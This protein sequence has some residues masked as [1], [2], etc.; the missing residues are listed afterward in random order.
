[1]RKAN[2]TVPVEVE[3]LFT[4]VSSGDSVNLQKL[5][6]KIL[7]QAT[8]VDPKDRLKQ[9]V[10]IY[11]KGN[12]K[13]F[14]NKSAL[15][16]ALQSNHRNAEKIVEIILAAGADA[17]QSVVPIEN[18]NQI[19]V[20]PLAIL[21][22]K[23]KQNLVRLLLGAQA[24]S[25][26]EFD[27][28]SSMDLL[29]V[30]TTG[31]ASTIKSISPLALCSIT[32]NVAM[33]QILLAHG[34]KH[35]H[36]LQR[37]RD[38][39]IRALTPFANS[40]STKSFP[41]LGLLYRHYAINLGAQAEIIPENQK[42]IPEF[43]TKGMII[44]YTTITE[45]YSIIEIKQLE[46]EL[47]ISI[48]HHPS[49]IT[50]AAYKGRLDIIQH[51]A[52]EQF[53]FKKCYCDCGYLKG[54]TPLIAAVLG[55]H[56]GLVAKL[57]SLKELI[58]MNEEAADGQYHHYTALCC[59]CDLGDVNMVRMLKSQGADIYTISSD[60]SSPL[61]LAVSA[62]EN[63]QKIVALLLEKDV[64]DWQNP[65]HLLIRML[66]YLS[67]HQ[68]GDAQLI[69]MLQPPDAVLNATFQ[70]NGHQLN[71]ILIAIENHLPKLVQICLDKGYSADRVLS[72]GVLSGITALSYATGLRRLDAVRQCLASGASPCLPCGP[73][74]KEGHTPI[75]IAISLYFNEALELMLDK[76]NDPHQCIPFANSELSLLLVS[77]IYRNG[78]AMR[79]L[80]E[81]G[82]LPF[83]CQQIRGRCIASPMIVAIKQSAMD[84]LAITV[85]L[86]HLKVN[87]QII[88]LINKGTTP[89]YAALYF[90]DLA[91]AKMLLA[92]GAKFSQMNQAGPYR[93]KNSSQLM[94]SKGLTA[95]DLGID[96][97]FGQIILI[98][99]IRQT[100]L[101]NSQSIF[102]PA[103]KPEIVATDYHMVVIDDEN[104][105]IEY[106]L[107]EVQVIINRVNR[108][109][110]DDY[111]SKDTH[112]YI[113]YHFLRACEALL[114]YIDTTPEQ[115]IISRPVAAMM[116]NFVM[117]LFYKMPAHDFLQFAHM[118]SLL[119][120]NQFQLVQ[121]NCPDIKR[122][123]NKIT[124]TEF[125]QCH[126]VLVTANHESTLS[127]DELCT[128]LVMVIADV[129]PF[130]RDLQID[131]VEDF[132]LF[133][134]I[135]IITKLGLALVGQNY[136]LFLKKSGVEQEECLDRRIY[137]FINKDSAEASNLQLMLQQCLMIREHVGHEF[138]QDIK[139]AE[140]YLLADNLSLKQVFSLLT[141]LMTLDDKLSKAEKLNIVN[142]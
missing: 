23:D 85:L 79:K 117:H 77:I 20:P 16:I 92:N 44:Y 136:R 31:D 108:L 54:T 141:T 2:E 65:Q 121:S 19:A 130:A 139:L 91:T 41:M 15:F 55:S 40:L 7:S 120:S 63:C 28:Q 116:R 97:E 18:N 125:Y 36:S 124:Q 64:V 30:S 39:C 47:S 49:F 118:V 10:N 46:K 96:H 6:N 58:D 109:N 101:L 132:C 103:Q 67:A 56:L 113:S 66:A 53:D 50:Y 105:F 98:A 8:Y 71:L 11:Y 110:A 12:N 83:L 59:A 17:N 114:H 13:K 89:L 104:R 119:L 135:V 128:H 78:F 122:L 73:G 29:G 76:I 93:G 69:R 112:Y 34:T 14:L 90:G 57:A 100:D 131:T 106:C 51:L 70:Y 32:N 42:N 72:E 26:V 37:M 62:E 45:R 21:V 140:R 5:I 86:Q 138:N 127:A 48:L 94:Q 52:A 137:T 74:D 129:V 102:T 84:P 111:Y 81:K 142:P 38:R 35:T 43:F 88:A 4:L 9:F 27:L 133:P 95:F 82:A 80:L 68:K 115:N 99:P 60:K 3:E 123:D 22:I 126:Q 1:M 25:N 61:T 107:F 75:G 134:D 87:D 33:V 24:D